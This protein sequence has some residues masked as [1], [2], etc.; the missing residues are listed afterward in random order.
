VAIVIATTHYNDPEK[1]AEVSKGLGE[2]MKGLDIK[3]IPEEQ[4]LQTR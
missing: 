2:P 1:V 3:L 4:L